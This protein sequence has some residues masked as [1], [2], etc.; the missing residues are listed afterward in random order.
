MPE[1][2]AA[3]TEVEQYDTTS[4]S[5]CTTEV[6][7]GNSAPRDTFEEHGYVVLAG[8]GDI[9]IENEA[10]GNWSKSVIFE[11]NE[12]NTDVPDVEG[13]VICETCA[14]EFH[15]IDSRLDNF[16]GHIPA[17]IDPTDES[18]SIE[19]IYVLVFLIVIFI[20]LILFL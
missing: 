15:E 2:K 13:H 9:T 10:D 4:C 8:E 20:M 12:T 3:T 6:V 11:L 18:N 5:I 1:R 14:N 19:L 16:Y 7:V 17:E